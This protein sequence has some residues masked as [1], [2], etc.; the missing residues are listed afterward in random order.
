MPNIL[1]PSIPLDA[2]PDGSAVIYG[3][4]NPSTAPVDRRYTLGSLPV[5]TPT[6]QL[7]DEKLGA[8]G[9]MS[10]KTVTANY[11]LTDEDV[12]I[13]IFVNSA[14]PVTVTIGTQLV[15]A[16]RDDA[17][18]E[19]WAVG[20]GEVTVAAAAGVDLNGADGG[21]V[22]IPSQYQAVAVVRFAPDVMI[23]TVP[24]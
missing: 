11:T 18:W 7:L 9:V 15:Q 17:G 21:S 2:E 16:Y 19:L 3:V 4:N 6:A 23:C 1:D 20:A 13:R 10:S 5:S 22:V 8:T 12:G 14:S 24:A